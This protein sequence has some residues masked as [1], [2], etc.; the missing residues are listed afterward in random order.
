MS[1]ELLHPALVTVLALLQYFV[2]AGLVGR[3]RGKYKVPAPQTSGNPDFERVLRVQMNTGEQLLIFV[4]SLWI[5]SLV[6]SALWGAGLGAVF[7]LGRIVYAVGYYKAA[8]KRG[9]GFAITS[10]GNLGLLVGSLVGIVM[11]FVQS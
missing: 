9:P 4:P 3:A 7:I 2:F 11:R 5:F 1:K 6:N 8:E 10:I